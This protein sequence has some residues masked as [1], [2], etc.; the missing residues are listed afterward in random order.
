MLELSGIMS[1]DTTARNGTRF[2]AGAL[3]KGLVDHWRMGLPSSLSHDAH[4]PAGWSF[5]T[6][7]SFE[8]GITRLH[9]AFYVPETKEEQNQINRMYFKY[10]HQNVEDIT[11]PFIGILRERLK[12]YLDG[13]EQLISCSSTALLSRNLARRVAPEVFALEDGK[14][15]V[16]LNALDEIHAGVYRFNDL[17][18]YAHPYFRRSLSRLNNL[19]S[20]LLDKLSDLAH[21]PDVSVKVRLDSDLVGLAA[22]AQTPIELAYWYGPPYSDD[23]CSISPGVNRQEA[24]ELL[25]LYLGISRTEFWWQSRSG[26]HILEAEELRDTRT[27]GSDSEQYGCRYVHSVVDE[28]TNHIEHLDGAIR[29][30]SETEMISRLDCAIDDAGR[31]TIYTKLWRVDG[32]ISLA[33]WKLLVHHHFRDNPLIGDYLDSEANA[34]ARKAIGTVFQPKDE[35]RHTKGQYTVSELLPPRFD[36]D[37]PV[38]V[39][40]SFHDLPEEPIASDRV[41]RPFQSIEFNDLRGEVIEADTTEIGKL[42]RAQ[43][44]NLD[45]PTGTIRLAFEDLY[46]SF[47]LIVH[48]TYDSLTATLDAFCLLFKSWNDRGHDRVIATS[49]GLVMSN[50][51]LRVSM[52]GHVSQMRK[53]VHQYSAIFKC[54]TYESMVDWVDSMASSLSASGQTADTARFIDHLITPNQTLRLQRVPIDPDLMVEPELVNGIPVLQ[55]RVPETELDLITALGNNSIE[56]CASVIIHEST[57]SRC[58]MDYTTCACSKYFDQNV[59]QICT[60]ADPVRLYWTDR[61]AR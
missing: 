13:S 12:D 28:G 57:C 55:L 7:L 49:F 43:G 8:P 27:F 40:L 59:I 10:M 34:L 29:E 41:V 53:Y 44:E 39:L 45:I 11:R 54:N 1:T 31:D 56:A 30:Y 26:Q 24:D 2:S 17:L 37:E 33:D 3:L 25:N 35:S 14:G 5:P 9:G 18:L 42:L 60:H 61:A 50:H 19:N 22:S 52:V 21:A 38:R 47:P 36:E 58:K 51:E 48:S 6:A 16:S 20:A 46:H 23:L 32:T 15:L 4:R